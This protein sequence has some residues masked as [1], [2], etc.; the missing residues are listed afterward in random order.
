MLKRE[1][2]ALVAQAR[3]DF[4][5][6]TELGRR[7]LIGVDGFPKHE[8]LAL[9]YLTHPSLLNGVESPRIIAEHL[10]LVRI[11]QAG[12]LSVLRRAA[13]G[14]SA[15]AQ[16]KL[17]AWSALTRSDPGEA[18]QWLSSAARLG[19]L[20]AAQTVSESAAKNDVDALVAALRRHWPTGF[21]DLVM[22]AASHSSERGDLERLAFN[23]RWALASSKPPAIPV[24]RLLKSALLLAQRTEQE[25][26]GLSSE[27]VEGCLLTLA[28]SGDRDAA[29]WLGGAYCGTQS[30]PLKA[31]RLRTARNHRRGCALLTRAADGGAHEAWMHLYHVY[32]DRRSSVANAQLARYIL[33]K[34]AGAGLV[35]ARRRL[36]ALI[37]RGSTTLQD[38]EQGVQHLHAA[39]LAG[40]VAAQQLLKTLV[41]PVAG[42]DAEASHALAVVRSSDPWLATRLQLARQFGLTKLEALSLDPAR[43]QRPWGLVVGPNPYI[44]L[45]GLA[46]PRAV[47][48][49][50][51]SSLDC[52]HRAALLFEE[53]ERD[54]IAPEGGHRQRSVQLRRLFIRHGISESLFFAKATTRTLA[55]LRSG[56]KWS[57][58]ARECLTVALA[59][60]RE[61]TASAAH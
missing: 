49:I 4:S 8:Q 54:R 24:A 44:A 3:H 47:P 60:R 12:C 48:A 55:S 14:A 16:Y 13:S 34:A 36:G 21:T 23:I 53:A 10:D 46:S 18:Q 32:S 11:V 40:D 1:H 38:S 35:E 33:E 17:G 51:P 27:E 41:L 58:R 22:A 56:P 7:Y 19:H 6:R 9:E 45:T 29:L 59:D 2:A 15:E 39:S 5:A 31:F 20:L 26:T 37:L 28:A 57:V 30:L 50:D 43:C 42:T 25:L 52:V 61:S